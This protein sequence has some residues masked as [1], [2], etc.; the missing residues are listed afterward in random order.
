MRILLFLT[1]S[2]CSAISQPIGKVFVRVDT[3]LVDVFKPTRVILDDDKSIDVLLRHEFFMV[4]SLSRPIYKRE[5]HNLNLQPCVTAYDTSKIL[6]HNRLFY[7]SK[8]RW[9]S[10]RS[11]IWY[12]DFY[13]FKFDTLNLR[14][15]TSFGVIDST[16]TFYKFFHLN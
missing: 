13:K 15:R 3:T 8:W 6:D 11:F 10:Q 9:Q 5:Y 7:D 14:L 16:E 1:L 4:D 12:G 2:F